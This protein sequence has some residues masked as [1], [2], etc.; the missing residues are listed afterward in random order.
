MNCQNIAMAT[1]K[2]KL[3]RVVDGT[4]KFLP[5]TKQVI[6]QLAKHGMEHP[7]ECI[8]MTDIQLMK[9]D[10][11]NR[12]RGSPGMRGT[13]PDLCCFDRNLN[14]IQC[15]KHK[16]SISRAEFQSKLSAQDMV[17]EISKGADSNPNY[18]YPGEDD[19]ECELF[20]LVGANVDIAKINKEPVHL[21]FLDSLKCPVAATSDS[22]SIGICPP[23]LEWVTK[24]I[25]RCTGYHL[26]DHYVTQKEKET[27]EWQ[28]KYTVGTNLYIAPETCQET[29]IKTMC[30]IME[31][32]NYRRVVSLDYLNHKA[33]LQT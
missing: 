17:R 24:W 20:I 21:L 6:A 18:F 25:N 28:K 15:D 1:P 10:R 4:E 26:S 8:E 9:I 11:P 33:K 22:W 27:V 7:K 3:I 16:T 30:V 23:T 5:L 14:R 31:G 12:Q 32:P 2:W 29:G 13:G 19:Y